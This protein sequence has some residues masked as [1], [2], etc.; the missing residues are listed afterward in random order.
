QMAPALP[1]PLAQMAPA[2]TTKPAEDADINT[3]INYIKKLLQKGRD[4]LL[5]HSTKM[6]TTTTK[7]KKK[8]Q[9][10]NILWIL[11]NPA[12]QQRATFQTRSSVRSSSRRSPAR[13]SQ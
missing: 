13:P 9:Q 11:K 12:A 8:Q 3:Q 1:A 2:P 7:K 10:N 6:T 5:Y 4:F